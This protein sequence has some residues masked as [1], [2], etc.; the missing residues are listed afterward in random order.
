MCIGNKYVVVSDD[1]HTST[2]CHKS[3]HTGARGNAIVRTLNV[4][5]TARCGE[6]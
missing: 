3:I 1:R 6:F 4:V 2:H 5:V